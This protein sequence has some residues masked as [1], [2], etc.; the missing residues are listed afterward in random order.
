[1]NDEEESQVNGIDQMIFNKIIEENFPKLRKE[2]DMDTRS[3]Q[4]T[5]KTRPENTPTVWKLQEKDMQVKYKGKPTRKTDSW[6]LTRNL[7][8]QKTLE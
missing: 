6:L 2:I 5:K 7:E 1:M 8:S 3:T 4:D